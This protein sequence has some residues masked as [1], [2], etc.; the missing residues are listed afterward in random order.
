MWQGCGVVRFWRR[1]REDERVRFVV[2]GGINTVVA[3]VL[4][5][6]FEQI[7]DGRYLLSLGLSYLIATLI[8]FFLHR[9]FT[10]AV[11]GRGMII[12]DFIRFESVYVVM[13]AINAILLFVLVDLARWPSWIAQALIIVVT[14]IVS[15]VG[16]K[17]FSFRRAPV[18]RDEVPDGDGPS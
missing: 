4:F 18:A 15:Y 9:R 1:V 6:G 5:L 13:L 12:L 8:A 3:Y 7:L 14:T 2:V 17:F 16:H 11:S 10:F